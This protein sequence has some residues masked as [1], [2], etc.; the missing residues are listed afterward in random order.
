MTTLISSAR[1]SLPKVSYVKAIDWYLLFCLI[2][3]FGSIME[4]TFVAF[5]IN[6]KNKTKIAAVPNR[7]STASSKV[8]VQKFI[9]VINAIAII[10]H[11]RIYNTQNELWGKN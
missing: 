4:Y 8:R 10:Y 5:I 3:V 11:N 6:I 2:F 9:V 7:E 1:A